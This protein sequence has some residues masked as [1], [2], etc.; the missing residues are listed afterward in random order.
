MSDNLVVIMFIV[1]VTAV[2]CRCCYFLL[3][4]S[5]KKFTNELYNAHTYNLLL[6]YRRRR[7]DG[8]ESDA[9]CWL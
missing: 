4:K 3:Q 8:D 7:D 5:N 1:T 9:G 6:Q 2:Q